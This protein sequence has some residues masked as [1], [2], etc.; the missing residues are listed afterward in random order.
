MSETAMA[1]PDA[2]PAY[3][4]DSEWPP[5]TE[6]V[7]LDTNG[8]GVTCLDM[9]GRDTHGRDEIE[10]DGVDG[11]GVE[12]DI[13]GAEPIW[14]SRTVRQFGAPV[15]SLQWEQPGVGSVGESNRMWR[16]LES[17]HTGAGLRLGL[18]VSEVTGAASKGS[19]RAIPLTL[20][21]PGFA[22]D[23]A[24]Y[25]AA[26]FGV[27]FAP[28][29]IRQFARRRRGGCVGCGY[30]LRATESGVCPECGAPA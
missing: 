20:L 9:I 17:A 11:E 27:F 28:G 15:R 18:D 29:V 7:E 1:P 23:T 16:L 21:W 5:P 8:F 12:A 25:G 14:V 10:R 26:W 4:V 22:I 6:A 30:D 24:F 2:W 3:L 13:A 19:F